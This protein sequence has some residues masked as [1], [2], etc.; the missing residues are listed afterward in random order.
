L[1]PRGVLFVDDERARIST[2]R[3]RY[4]HGQRNRCQFAL[5]WVL[6]ADDWIQTDRS[7][8]EIHRVSEAAKI[9]CRDLVRSGSMILMPAAQTPV[10][11]DAA[12]H[13]FELA[14]SASP[15]ATI[16]V[17]AIGAATNAASALL[18]A[19]TI[20]PNLKALFWA[21]F[22]S[23]AESAGQGHRS[24]LG[25]LG[26]HRRPMAS[27]PKLVANSRGSAS[28]RATGPSLAPSRPRGGYARGL[29]REA[30]CHL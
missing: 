1:P 29:P 18:T 15:Q 21:G 10:P 20:A 13:L 19:P 27:E 5:A 30:Q 6:R 12:D 3:D 4:R 2:H 16:H 17:A 22:P 28:G 25:S 14:H 23:G 7:L 8:I 26:H 11:S 9:S 24:Q